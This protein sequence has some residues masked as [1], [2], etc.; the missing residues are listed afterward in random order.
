M[1]YFL[2]F[3]LITLSVLSDT[4]KDITIAGKPYVIIHE[5]YNEYSDKGIEMKLYSKEQ[6]RDT[7]PLLSFTL[8]NQ[9]GGCAEKSIQSGTYAIEGDKII[10]Y[11]HWARSGRA[12]DAPSGDR[13][14]IYKFDKDGNLTRV[15]GQVYI[16]K[17]KRGKE[18]DEGMKY[19]Y[20]P[21]ITAKEKKAL[22]AYI[23]SVEHIFEAD[24][25]QGEQANALAN[26]VEQALREKSKQRWQ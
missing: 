26:E 1:K 21:A 3:L 8:E 15:S 5:S 19:L 9:S 22:T 14:Q 24:F 25:V 6:N 18:M 13:K 23:R 2:L 10:L 20:T 11:S 12:Y 7:L 16:E 17:A 4:I